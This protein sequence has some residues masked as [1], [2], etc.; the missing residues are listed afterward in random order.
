MPIERTI[1]LYQ[2]DEL[3]DRAKER[4]REWFRS[5][6]GNTDDE[7]WYEHIYE[8]F[9]EV[10]ECLG[11]ELD[12][13]TVRLMGGGTRQK[14]DISW[15]GFWSQGD[16]ACFNGVYRTYINASEAIRKYAPQDTELH[17]IADR[18]VEL[19]AAYPEG[20]FV[21]VK[22]SGRYSHANTMHVD[23]AEANEVYNEETEEWCEPELTDEDEFLGCLR[24]LADWL[25]SSLNKTYEWLESDEQIDES[26]R[27]NEYTFLE[28]GARHD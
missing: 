5:V 21:R 27:A 17:G 11:V 1:K 22:S 26:I 6:G 10:C 23:R 24:D 4:A 19:S 3:D 15:S 9:E 8:D 12:T 7:S 25:Y 20:V 28:D 13:H 2:F 14:P 16:G 18:L